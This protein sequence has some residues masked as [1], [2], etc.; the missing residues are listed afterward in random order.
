M[1]SASVAG[2]SI[3]VG[4]HFLIPRYYKVVKFEGKDAEKF[5]SQKTLKFPPQLAEKMRT[6]RAM[7]CQ[8]LGIANHFIYMKMHQ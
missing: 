8:L 1:N 4:V 7:T 6:H 2:Y 3:T 5:A